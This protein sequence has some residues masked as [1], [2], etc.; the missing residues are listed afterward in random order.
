VP[1]APTG[2]TA[3]RG[4]AQVALSWTA[5]VSNGG[6]AI[7]A[8]TVTAS[9]G[10]ATCA[11]TGATTCTVTGLTNGT[12]YSFTATATNAVGTS[13]ASAPATATPATVPGA[14]TGLT[15]K[16]NPPKGVGLTWSAPASNGGSSITGYQIYRSTTSGSETSPVTVGNVTTYVDTTTAKGVRYYYQVTA[17][18]ALGEGPRSLESSAVAK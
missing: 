15:A 11:T 10:G 1:G 16:T 3:T 9:P 7:T 13:V 18:N 12:L 4:N 2:L 17:I 8:Y 5:P 14:P 6:S